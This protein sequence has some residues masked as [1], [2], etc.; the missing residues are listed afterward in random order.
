MDRDELIRHVVGVLQGLSVPVS[1]GTP[2]GAAREHWQ[3]I[4]EAEGFPFGWPSDEDVDE[5]VRGILGPKV[6][7]FIDLRRPKGEVPGGS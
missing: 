2:L 7:L 3:A 6:D 1:L 4:R 5:W